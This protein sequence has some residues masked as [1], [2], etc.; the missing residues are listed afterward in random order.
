MPISK[1]SAFQV[2]YLQF[3]TNL[4]CFQKINAHV[5]FTKRKRQMA[6]VGAF[7]SRI[8]HRGSLGIYLECT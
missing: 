7:L 4:D 3:F 2:E 1:F 5:K 6:N 8:A